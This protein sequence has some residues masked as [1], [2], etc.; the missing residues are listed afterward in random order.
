MS[1]TF[2]IF[3]FDGTLAQTLDMVVEILRPMAKEF[4]LKEV[5]DKDIK[6]FREK[7]IKQIIKEFKIPLIKVPIIIKRV[8]DKLNKETENLS[9]FDGIKETLN[10]L[11]KKNYGLGILTSNS[12][13]NV[14]M[15]LKKNDLDLFDFIYSDSSLF[16]KDKVLKKLFKNRNLKTN[17][18]V[19]FGDEVRDIQAA[20]KLKIKMV[21]VS[22]GFNTKRLLTSYKPTYLVENPSQILRLFS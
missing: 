8:K 17:Q 9:T 3:D 22:W 18:V 21:A 15:F 20:F 6:A 13:D 1:K 11:K 16:G 14:K 10:E 2:L 5:S 4:G 12:E 7:G 19:Y